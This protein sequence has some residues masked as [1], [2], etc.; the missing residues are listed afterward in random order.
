MEIGVAAFLQVAAFMLCP[1]R[2]TNSDGNVSVFYP[3]IVP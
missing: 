3:S 1:E 2:D